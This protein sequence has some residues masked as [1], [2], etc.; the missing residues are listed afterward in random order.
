M[1][2]EKGPVNGAANGSPNG[3]IIDVEKLAVSPNQPTH[4]ATLLG[5][6]NTDGKE[7]ID[8]DSQARLKMLETARSLVYALETPREAI[9]RHCWSEV[10]LEWS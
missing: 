4:I 5:Q 1:T 6:L 8:T 2:H 9:I 3:K 10:H 7:H